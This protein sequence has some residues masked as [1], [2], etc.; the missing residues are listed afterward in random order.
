MTDR[1]AQLLDEFDCVIGPQKSALAGS[2]PSLLSRYYAPPPGLPVQPARVGAAAAPVGVA[3]SSKRP[4]GGG[5][6]GEPS[7]KRAKPVPPMDEDEKKLDEMLK[8]VK[9]L[10]NR[11]LWTKKECN[12]FKEPVDPIK[13]NIP[14]YHAY[15]K[16]PMDVGTVRKKLDQGAYQNPLQVRDDLRLVWRNCATYNPPGHVVRNNGD[17]LAAA[18]ENAWAESSMERRWNE[19]VLQKDPKVIQNKVCRRQLI[20]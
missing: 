9:M 1:R 11:K 12:A 19:Y 18:W 5:G 20:D 7:S 6:G 4:A 17:I 13:L 3:K 10:I 15:V 8:D 14:D 16:H 2:I